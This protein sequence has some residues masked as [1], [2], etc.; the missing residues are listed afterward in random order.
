M[1]TAG[2]LLWRMT[3]AVARLPLSAPMLTLTVPTHRTPA[4]LGRGEKAEARATGVKYDANNLYLAT[5]YAVSYNMTPV[6]STRGFANK[7]QNFEAV[8]QYQF[9]FGLRPSTGLRPDQGQRHGKR[10][11]RR[12]SG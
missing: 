10:H 5:M 6:S 9:D 8:V 7:A 1:A 11:W 2:V 12:R 3:S 4:A